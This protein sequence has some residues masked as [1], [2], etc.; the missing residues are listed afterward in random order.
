M[1]S[2]LHRP[3]GV[4]KA[5]WDPFVAEVRSMVDHN[6]SEYQRFGGF[7]WFDTARR[8]SALKCMPQ[9]KKH[10]LES[11]VQDRFKENTH[12]GKCE[13]LRIAAFFYMPRNVADLD[14]NEQQYMTKLPD[15]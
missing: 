12:Q 3:K 15:E 4:S 8:Q 13:V 2:T 9:W 10:V 14:L 11:M 7:R 6:Y 5:T 1:S